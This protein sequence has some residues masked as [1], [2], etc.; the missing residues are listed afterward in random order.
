MKQ[1]LIS[2]EILTTIIGNGN[3][4]IQELNKLDFPF[5][6]NA[7]AI[8]D[9]SNKELIKRINAGLVPDKENEAVNA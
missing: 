2:E 9:N 5:K 7:L 8:I 3:Y 4:I 1:Y 6:N